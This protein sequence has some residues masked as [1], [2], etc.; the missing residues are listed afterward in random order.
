VRAAGDVDIGTEAVETALRRVDDEQAYGN[1]IIG[2]MKSSKANPEDAPHP[3][4]A[5]ESVVIQ[6]EIK[7]ENEFKR[8]YEYDPGAS[9]PHDN[10]D[11]GFVMRTD[12]LKARDSPEAVLDDWALLPEWQDYNHVGRLHISDEFA[13]NNREEVLIS[14]TRKQ[15]SGTTDVVRE[16]GAKQYILQTELKRGSDGIQWVPV[17]EL[18]KFVK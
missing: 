18:D 9:D 10:L 6:A 17:E 1:K 11:G 8:V 3:P 16:G 2:F 15:E 4:H 12:A 5:P 13:K 7:S 14:T